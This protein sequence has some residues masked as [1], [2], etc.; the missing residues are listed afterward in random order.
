MT[1]RVRAFS[2]SW[3][4]RHKVIDYIK[5]QDNHHRYIEFEQEYRSLQELNDREAKADFLN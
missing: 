1:T 3:S 5:D 4:I 2:V